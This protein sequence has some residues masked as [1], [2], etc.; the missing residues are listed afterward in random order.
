MKEETRIVTISVI[1][2]IFGL[3]IIVSTI[4]FITATLMYQPK[5]IWNTIISIILLIGFALIA[6]GLFGIGLKKY[7]KF[8][9]I[10]F[11]ISLMI[12]LLVIIAQVMFYAG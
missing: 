9:I 12:Y 11:V 3:W 8:L 1:N 5:T 4:P 7:E 2:I 6:T 10:F